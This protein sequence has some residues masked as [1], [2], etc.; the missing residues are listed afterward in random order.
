[1]KSSNRFRSQRG[2]LLLVA[3]VFAAV[4]SIVLT[5]YLR[6]S[7]TALNLA[8]R[9]FY[10]NQAMNLTESGL[11]LAMAQINTNSTTWPSPWTAAP[12]SATDVIATF[13]TSIT[14]PHGVTG[15]VMVHVQNYAGS[16]PLVVA[17]GIVVP[18]SGPPIYK[19][20]EVS[21]IAQRS[22]FAKGLVGRNGLSFS[23]NNA[24]VD[25]WDSAYDS[26]GTIRATPVGYSAAVKDDN[27]SIAA[28]NITATDAVGNA[29]IWGSAS[30]GGS[31]TSLITVGPQ[32]SVGPFGTAAGTK[33]T[34]SISG[35]FT[36][37]LP[38]VVT[39]NPATVPT[40]LGS[41]TNDLTL[42]R[43][44]DTITGDTYYYSVTDVTLSGNSKVLKVSA[45]KKVVLL[46][47]TLTGGDAI[48]ITGNS[49]KIEVESGG[50]LDIYTQANITIA[51]TGIVN[52]NSTTATDS[53]QIWGTNT[54][55][56]ATNGGIAAQTITISGNGSLA[57]TCYA[58]N[59]SLSAKGGGNSGSIYG[60]FVAYSVTMTGNDAFH[61][62]ENLGRK[63]NT[64]SFNPSKWREL[65]NKT[66]RDTYASYF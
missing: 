63:G 55:D 49:S 12:N 21:G 13:S 60:S 58:P 40:L 22:L 35:N 18:A 59:A 1:M 42:P 5:S 19:M 53:I 23:G 20:V 4:I 14:L 16:S 33:A 66:D 3:M 54:T 28:V 64:G 29:N 56:P 38:A 31:S 2:S 27:G 65:V 25:S 37:N 24:S 57:C 7:V 36:A 43:G 15:Q 8:Q 34:N 9:A 47:S 46:F 41:V 10:A 11:E 62:D 39:P 17:K 61:Y 45:D 6:L 44:T 32:G 50:H 26:T 48:K 30:V 52:G 51:G